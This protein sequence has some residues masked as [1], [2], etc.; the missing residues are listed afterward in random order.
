MAYSLVELTHYKGF[1]Y[2]FEEGMKFEFFGFPDRQQ[3]T[4][5]SCVYKVKLWRFYYV[6]DRLW[7]GWGIILSSVL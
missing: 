3:K 5:K 7:I 2:V 1:K 4:E 6:L